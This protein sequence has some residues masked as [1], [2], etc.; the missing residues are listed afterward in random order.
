MHARAGALQSA[1]GFLKSLHRVGRKKSGMAAS[2]PEDVHGLVS[3]SDGMTLASTVERLGS[4]DE[5]SE[6]PS[7]SAFVKPKS[8]L[9]DLDGKQHRW[10]LVESHS[11][12]G[13]ILYHKTLDA[14]VL[15]R[16]FRPAVYAGACRQ[17]T[18]EGRQR[19]PYSVGFTYELCAGILDK[20]E[21]SLAEVAAEEV[22]EECGYSIPASKLSKVSSYMSA[23]GISGTRQT[24]FYGEIDESMRIN[25]GGGVK[26]DGE[27]IQVLAL[28]LAKSR[29]FLYDDS[30]PKSAGL[31]FALLW[32]LHER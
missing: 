2:N 11:S 14:L 3:L 9:Y 10:D 28:P 24:F 6:M 7:P 15:V 26:H 25:N 8:I 13:A 22:A 12:V 30:L 16:Q 31:M 4:F 5:L 18:K 20:D 17:A 23:I 29:E 27:A 32:L 21:L 19:P 1:R